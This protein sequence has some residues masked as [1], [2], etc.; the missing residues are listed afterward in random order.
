M[1][2]S[3]AEAVAP[4]QWTPPAHQRQEYTAADWEEWKAWKRSQ[5]STKVM[6]AVHSSVNT[7]APPRVQAMPT[8]QTM[9]PTEDGQ[10]AREKLEEELNTLVDALKLIPDSPVLRE[11]RSQL[12]S[13]QEQLKKQITA[14]RP[15]ASRLDTCIAAVERAKKRVNQAAQEEE[16]ARCAWEDLCRCKVAAEEDLQEKELQL[17]VLR[18]SAIAHGTCSSHSQSHPSGNSIEELESNMTQILAEMQQGGR[19]SHHRIKE[20]MGMMSA[21]FQ[22]LQDVALECKDQDE[23]RSEAS[24]VQVPTGNPIHGGAAPAGTSG[25][26]RPAETD[27]QQLDAMMAQESATYEDPFTVRMHEAALA[28]GG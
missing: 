15:L 24:T 25:A 7:H 13:R 11:T 28:L 23:A 20:A 22:H 17:S 6:N 26:K 5:P 8:P 19:A 14:T 10:S 4:K 3:W 9:Q 21:L 1:K 2:K 12:T 16:N 18:E 27:V